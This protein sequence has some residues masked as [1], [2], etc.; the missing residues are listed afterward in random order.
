[1]RIG[2]E[3]AVR[4]PVNELVGYIKDYDSYGFE[5]IWVPD[6]AFSQWEVWTTA[7]LAAMYTTTARIGVGVMAPYHRNPAVIAHGAATLDQLSGGRVDLSIGRGSRPYIASIDADRPD[8]AVTEAITIING[9]LS[10]ET[11]SMEGTAFTF[12]EVSQRVRPVQ[13]HVSIAIASMS[14][15]WLD[16]ARET[17]D[18]VHLYTSNPTLLGTAQEAKKAAKNPDFEVTTT[19]GYVEPEEV[20]EWWVTNF[21]RNFNLQQLCGREPNTASYEELAAELV[22]TDA[23]SLRDHLQRME[24]FGVDELMIAYRRAEDLPAIAEMVAAARG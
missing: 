19:L 24:S 15:Y 20:R 11:V 5:R 12:N 9:L 4:T 13:E 7:T 2:V 23:A 8:E 22:F 10:G 6:A 18:G 1:M 17:V 14:R 3:L 21:G 16:I